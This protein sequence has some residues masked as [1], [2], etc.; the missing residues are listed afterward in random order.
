MILSSA[1]SW[2]GKAATGSMPSGHSIRAGKRPSAA[3]PPSSR[4][5]QPP[6]QITPCDLDDSAGVIAAGLCGCF[7]IAHGHDP[8]QR[9]WPFCQACGRSIVIKRI[10]AS[11]RRQ[12]CRWI[13]R[14]HLKISTA[15]TQ[16]HQPVM[17]GHQRGVR[18]RRQWARQAALQYG[19]WQPA[20]LLL[21]SR[22]GQILHA[23][24]V[25]EDAGP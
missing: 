13:N 22:H 16:P 12:R 23:L 9:A 2:T 10:P 3:S 6:V 24:Q 21:R 4:H 20:D 7:D 19:Q 8:A 5:C 18:R 15:S 14:D 1:T 11:A 25:P 17:R